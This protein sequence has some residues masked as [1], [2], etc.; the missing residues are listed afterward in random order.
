MCEIFVETNDEKLEKNLISVDNVI[1][2]VDNLIRG[3]TIL[4]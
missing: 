4:I 3:L 2:V 1:K